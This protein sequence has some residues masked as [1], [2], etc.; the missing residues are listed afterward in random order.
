VA[1]TEAVE[2]GQNR[3]QVCDRPLPI[4]LGVGHKPPSGGHRQREPAGFSGFIRLWPWRAMSSIIGRVVIASTSGQ[5]IDVVQIL[6][7]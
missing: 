5:G 3:L 1:A 6:E 4:P 7:G 2:M